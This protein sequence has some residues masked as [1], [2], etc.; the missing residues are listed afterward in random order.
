MKQNLIP[1]KMLQN[2]VL[3]KMQQNIL[4]SSSLSFEGGRS[5]LAPHPP[6]PPKKNQLATASTLAIRVH[7]ICCRVRRFVSDF[8]QSNTW[9]GSIGGR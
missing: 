8:C 1:D 3:Y 6:T 2:L 5:E 9:H 4:P 7:F